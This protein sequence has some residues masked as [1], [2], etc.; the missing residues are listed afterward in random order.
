[1]EDQRRLFQGP[2]ILPA[3]EGQNYKACYLKTVHLEQKVSMKQE[4]AR[5]G[6]EGLPA[7]FA[8]LC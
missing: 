6:K 7:N 5:I 3:K 2:I 4:D 8:C 1:M